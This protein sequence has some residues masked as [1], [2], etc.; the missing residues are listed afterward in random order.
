MSKSEKYNE[1]PKSLG[2]KQAF[3]T[4]AKRW[5]EWDKKKSE[6]AISQAKKLPTSKIPKFMGEAEKTAE[7]TWNDKFRDAF[8]RV[9]TDRLKGADYH[10]KK[11]SSQE[12][13]YIMFFQ[14]RNAL[15]KL[16]ITPDRYSHELS[17]EDRTFEFEGLKGEY[18]FLY[19]YQYDDPDQIINI[20]RKCLDERGKEIFENYTFKRDGEGWYSKNELDSVKNVKTIIRGNFTSRGS[21]EKQRLTLRK[22]TKVTD[23]ICHQANQL[24]QGSSSI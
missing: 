4:A 6:A 18:K 10:D 21:P 24:P 2:I 22:L 9:D 5:E 1:E 11:L 7:A 17:P 23:T 19:Y 3:E 16:D 20:S 15:E 8:G 14:L 12:R 13:I